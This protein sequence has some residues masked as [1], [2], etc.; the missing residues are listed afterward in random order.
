MRL[1]R[2]SVLFFCL[3]A[4]SGA[5]WAHAPQDVPIFPLP[6]LPVPGPIQSPPIGSE[7]IIAKAVPAWQSTP[8]VSSD[9]RLSGELIITVNGDPSTSSPSWIT[10]DS[11]SD[12]KSRITSRL[13][14][15]WEASLS[16]GSAEL[17]ITI[18][19][20]DP[21]GEFSVVGLIWFP[22]PGPG[23][24]YISFS[25]EHG[26]LFLRSASKGVEGIEIETVPDAMPIDLRRQNWIWR[27]YD[28]PV[29]TLTI[30]HG[31]EKAKKALDP[32]SREC[33]EQY[34]LARNPDGTIANVMEV[35][36]D[37]LQVHKDALQQDDDRDRLHYAINGA[38]PLDP[39]NGPFF[40][41]ISKS[42]ADLWHINW[43]EEAKGCRKYNIT[44][45]EHGNVELGEPSPRGAQIL[46]GFKS[47]YITVGNAKVYDVALLQQ[48]LNGTAAQLAA[49]SGFSAG[50]ITGAYGNLQGV[51][52][53]T[54][55]LSAQVTTTPL[56]T[57]STVTG[58]ATPGQTSTT[59]TLQCPNG[60]LPTLGS[61]SGTEACTVPGTVATGATIPTTSTS[62]TTTIG[63]TTPGT[64]TQ[65]TASTT[66]AIGTVPT[67]PTSTAFS[68]PTNVGV[69]S[70]DILTEQVELNA[71]ITTLRLLLQGAL[72]DQYVIRHTR[73]VATRKQTTLGFT[74]TL[75]PPRQFRHAVAEVQVL[76]VPEPGID[77]VS[78]VN[79]LPAEKT[80]NVAKITSHQNAFG[81]GVAVAPVSVGVNTGKSKDRLYLAKDTDTLA[82]QYVPPI[83]SVEEVE[84]AFPQHAHDAYK[85]LVEFLGWHGL[86]DCQSPAEENPDLIVGTNATV[87]GWQFRPVLGEEYVRGGQRQVFA[88]LALPSTTTNQ[89]P[90]PRVYIL[91]RW[92]AYDPKRQVVGAVYTSSCSA[93][94][95]LSGIS[96]TPVIEVKD[97]KMADLGGGEIKLTN[98]GQFATPSVS[99][100]VGTTNVVPLTSDGETL[101]L[102]DNAH[103]LLAADSLKILGPSGSMTAFGM[104]AKPTGCEISRAKLNAVPYPDGNSRMTLK[105]TMGR[106]YV[107]EESA[108]GFPTPLVLVGS[109]VYG[110]KETPF[111]DDYKER[112]NDNQKDSQHQDAKNHTCQGHPSVCTYKFIAPTTAVRNAQTF[113]VK[114]LRWE[115]MSEKGT[116]HFFPSFA[117]LASFTAPPAPSGSSAPALPPCPKIDPKLACSCPKVEAKLC[118]APAPAATEDPSTTLMVSGFDFSDTL[119]SDACCSMASRQLEPCLKVLA[120]D[121]SQFAFDPVT[122]NVATLTGKQSI[123]AKTKTVRFVLNGRC[124][125]DGVD[126]YS[127]EWDLPMPKSDKAAGITA[128][129]TFLRVSDSAPVVFSG[130]KISTVDDT[131][132]MFDGTTHLPAKLSADG[133]TLTVYVTTTVTK[134]AGHKV[135]TVCI[136]GS[137]PAQTVQLQ[138]D[139]F[140]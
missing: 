93:V 5:V 14:K 24:G 77:G 136:K 92:R 86:A 121:G 3:V 126:E 22:D 26:A 42:N 21:S 37:G 63:T 23:E 85:G 2:V 6:I 69:S 12:I 115:N 11:I 67:A 83:P 90:A 9:Q 98:T 56:P 122:R 31:C 139:I 137:C 66:G 46:D 133:T 95:D 80:Y 99:V 70:A 72:S 53:D 79:L 120:G 131:T 15:D 71:Q 40:M 91:T 128:A 30:K 89:T 116:I 51:E 58:S 97:V 1:S 119:G 20:K 100:L 76:I 103:D 105:L 75:D 117:S 87:L 45:L 111:V 43:Y 38:S 49:I 108:D 127:V 13:P 4:G 64:T 19:P 110:L 16:P 34:L 39:T 129:P 35:T 102:F 59:V 55:Y 8:A 132:V 57:L 134:T 18:E 118:A 125:P 25:A 106:N 96:D 29:G 48:M 140:K 82:L 114:D 112:P 62:T 84:R 73:P 135:L 27:F 109:Q 61:S 28:K 10:G 60:S 7:H 104:K 130:D 47:N 107:A 32:Y 101:Q 44:P 36:K 81:A 88:Q 113:L 41:P 78:I 50:S 68:A 52:R 123:F 124:N 138:I 65:Q 54:S 17:R 33:I 94:P 74:I